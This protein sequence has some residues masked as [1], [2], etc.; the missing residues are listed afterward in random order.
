MS[1]YRTIGPLVLLIKCN[2][3]YSH[4]FSTKNNSVFIIFPF[5]ILTNRQLKMLLI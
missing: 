3:K 5:E 1:V 2:T 4:M